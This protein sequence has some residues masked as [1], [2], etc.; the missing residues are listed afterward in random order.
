MVVN[1]LTTES[2]I[3]GAVIMGLS[4]ALFEDR[5]M[6]PQTGRQINANLEDY[7][8]AGTMEIPEIVAIAYDTERKVT[9][10]GEPPTIPTAG[11]IAN[12]VHN[13]IGVRI[14]ELPITPDKVLKA[15]AE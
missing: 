6:D 8:V 15:L 2:Q 13:A 4:Y 11:A 14:R 10:I 5:I 12:A 7:K 1:R 3:N 9:G